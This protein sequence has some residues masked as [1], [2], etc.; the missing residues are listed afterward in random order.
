VAYQTEA[1]LLAWSIFE[2]AILNVLSQAEQKL[3]LMITG[4]F[5]LSSSFSIQ[6]KTNLSKYGDSATLPS[7]L[8]SEFTSMDN[9][10]ESSPK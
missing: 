6:R 4:S 7:Q 5:S 3:G 8:E 2:L 9:G 10:I 1:L